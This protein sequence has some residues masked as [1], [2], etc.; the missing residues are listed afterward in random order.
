MMS[1]KPFAVSFYAGR[2]EPPIRRDRFDTYEKAM[3][4]INSVL[5]AGGEAYRGRI[6]GKGI[7]VETWYWNGKKVY[8]WNSS[9]I[10]PRVVAEAFDPDKDK[11]PVA[12]VLRPLPASYFEREQRNERE[13]H[14]HSTE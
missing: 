12:A 2:Y 4:A 7:I 10:L 1:R 5:A 13:H 3:I 8:M 9:L 14:D 6:S 11:D